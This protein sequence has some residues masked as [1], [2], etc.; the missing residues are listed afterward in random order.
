[1]PGAVSRGRSKSVRRGFSPRARLVVCLNG[2][3]PLR[4]GVPDHRTKPSTA[5]PVALEN[6]PRLRE[7]S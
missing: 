7:L 1:M 6:R 3:G 2:P 4:P 5:K